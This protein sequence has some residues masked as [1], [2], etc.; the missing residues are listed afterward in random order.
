MKKH[1]CWRGFRS[2]WRPNKRGH[3][4]WGGFAFR[5][6][7][8]TALCGVGGIKEACAYG[9]EGM[10]CGQLSVEEVDH[11]SSRNFHLNV[12]TAL[13]LGCGI[14]R[15]LQLP[16]DEAQSRYTNKRGYGGPKPLWVVA[17]FKKWSCIDWCIIMAAIAIGGAFGAYTGIVHIKPNKGKRSNDR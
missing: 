1:F 5:L 17:C 15:S 7:L 4:R 16:P 3:T 2:L 9:G 10:F 14:R 13:S 11:P 6:L 8:A 12:N